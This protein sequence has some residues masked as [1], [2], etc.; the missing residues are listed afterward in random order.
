[1]TVSFRKRPYRL[2]K[3]LT[4]LG[5]INRENNEAVWERSLGEQA[6][7]RVRFRNPLAVPLSHCELRVDLNMRFKRDVVVPA[8]TVA[9]VST[10][11]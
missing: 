11:A 5:S 9:P 3:L 1:M 4:S 10:V 6:S 7:V 2:G 8:A